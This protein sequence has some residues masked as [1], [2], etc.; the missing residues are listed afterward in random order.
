MKHRYLVAVFLVLTV[1]TFFSIWKFNN[2]KKERGILYKTI[3]QIIGKYD[4]GET[5]C[6]NIGLVDSYPWDTLFV[7]GPYSFPEAIDSRLGFFW[8]GSR[9]TQIKD[10]DSVALL[11]F[12][13]GKTVRQYVEFYLGDGDFSMLHGTVVNK[14]DAIFKKND[15]GDI[16]HIQ[17]NSSN[18]CK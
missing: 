5:N 3:F 1:L 11:V 7:F 18:C 8:L 6:I 13:K 16:V 10:S 2:E 17:C 14:K 4:N 12:V 15:L 9:F